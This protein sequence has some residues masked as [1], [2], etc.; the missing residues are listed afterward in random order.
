MGVGGCLGRG[1]Q[2]CEI[3]QVAV[4]TE[5]LV[6]THYTKVFLAGFAKMARWIGGDGLLL[7]V[8][9]ARLSV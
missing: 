1:I 7:H 5:G 4:N 8:H 6:F 3:C 2:G 9:D